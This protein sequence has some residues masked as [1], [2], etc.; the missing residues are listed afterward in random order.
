VAA[1][2]GQQGR[3]VEAAADGDD[4]HERQRQAVEVNELRRQEERQAVAL[5]LPE[6]GVLHQPVGGTEQLLRLGGTEAGRD[7]A[8]LRLA[9]MSAAANRVRLSAAP[10][11]GHEDRDTVPLGGRYECLEVVTSKEIHG[12]CPP[13]SQRAPLAV[14]RG[15][16][17]AVGL[18][19]YT[20]R[21]PSV[22][23]ERPER[24]IR[25]VGKA[26]SMP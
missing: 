17:V 4:V 11:G 10:V 8:L 22:R 14:A 23:G 9:H 6:G 2:Q 5:V 24:A 19:R 13:A 21:L 25:A 26:T 16:A 15:D 18:E 7:Q 1:E 12:T 3:D 20:G